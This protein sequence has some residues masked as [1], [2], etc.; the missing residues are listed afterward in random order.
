M[1]RPR[2]FDAD[3]VL[4]KAM[5]VF[6]EKGYEGTSLRDLLAATGLNKQSLYGA[7]GNKQ[8]LYLAAL[9][10]YEDTHVRQA[11]TLLSGDGPAKARL[12]KLLHSIVDRA[13]KRSG[14]R[15]CMLCTASIDRA[16]LDPETRKHV[17]RC[18]GRLEK[19]IA[20]TLAESA[21]YDRDKTL[22]RKRARALLAAYFGL[23]VL[24][25]AGASKAELED[26]C[27]ATLM[28]L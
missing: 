27:E 14:P 21:P 7:F 28:A 11:T 17:R 16:T 12:A 4:N 6:W 26:A 20:A 19:A 15:G 18:I 22:R 24:A 25:K 8:D 2:E 3:H 10:T 9:K 23:N 13:V 1:A 5:R